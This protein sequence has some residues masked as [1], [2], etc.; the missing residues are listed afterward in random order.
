[1]FFLHKKHCLSLAKMDGGEMTVIYGGKGGGKRHK[2]MFDNKK[3]GSE[4]RKMQ[5]SNK[6]KTS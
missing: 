2:E 4:V 5:I 6:V 3:G 1:M